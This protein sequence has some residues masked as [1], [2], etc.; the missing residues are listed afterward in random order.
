MSGKVMISPF[1]VNKQLKTQNR[2][3]YDDN[4]DIPLLDLSINNLSTR[5]NEN[6]M[7]QDNVSVSSSLS[8]LSTF[9]TIIKC[10]V[11]GGSFSLPYAFQLGGVYASFIVTILLGY[12][13]F[14]TID[15]LV[16]CEKKYVALSRPQSQTSKRHLTYSEMG[17][18][19]FPNWTVNVFSIKTNL[20]S[21]LINLGIF[22]TCIGVCV[23]YI[24][25]IASIYPTVISD[26]HFATLTTVETSSH[27][28]ITPTMMPHVYSSTTLDPSSPLSHWILLPFLI[29]LSLISNYRYLI[30]TSTIGS[31]A[32]YLGLL[33]VVINGYHTSDGMSF[34][35]PFIQWR[36]F[37][38]YL[39][40]TCFL[41]AVHIVILPIAQSMEP[42]SYNSFR[43]VLFL[44]Y[45]TISLSNSVFGCLV[46]LLY[47]STVCSVASTQYPHGPC[48]N[49]LD[50]L[51]GGYLIG[52]VK[53]L[54]CID[55]LFSIPLILSSARELLINALQ[56]HCSSLKE[57]TVSILVRIFL[58]FLLLTLSSTIPDFGIV[59]DLVGG[60]CNSLMGF[61]LPP[62]LLL[63]LHHKE[64]W[65]Y[66][67]ILCQQGTPRWYLY[68]GGNIIII[69]FGFYLMI[70][71]TY[72][73]WISD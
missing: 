17:E 64:K 39:S 44:S 50:S 13:C 67:P 66:L 68:V 72:M 3:E 49:I 21:F 28:T 42:P 20:I 10:A 11:G 41:F 38:Q 46:Y 12:L 70:L 57:S 19:A 69:L 60:I 52:T 54:I 24:D 26:P 7:N 33:L 31:L 8:P 2:S 45:S 18:I 63:T 16:Y 1:E 23:A 9:I 22:S 35:H 5:L 65:R 48:P 61:V 47:S 34:S 6:M 15:I 59:I 37:T 53:S 30:T 36:T 4:D 29:A 56:S 58:P 32:V 71:T 14:H 40:R 43:R 55:L 25:I 51:S 27:P 62:I 73:A